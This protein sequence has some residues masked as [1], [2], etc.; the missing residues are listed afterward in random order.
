MRTFEYQIL[1]QFKGRVQAHDV[2]GALKN[3]IDD[4]Y[5]NIGNL[6]VLDFQFMT[7]KVSEVKQQEV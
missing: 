6:E 1:E 7:I 2:R 3:A 5:K 4:Y